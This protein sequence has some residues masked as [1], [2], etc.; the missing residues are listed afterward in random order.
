MT[1]MANYQDHDGVFAEM[2]WTLPRLSQKGPLHVGWALSQSPSIFHPASWQEPREVCGLWGC[3][4]RQ[5]ALGRHVTN[6]NFWFLQRCWWTT[7]RAPLGLNGQQQQLNKNGQW[8]EQWQL[9]ITND[10]DNKQLPKSGKYRGPRQN[11]VLTVFFL[12]PL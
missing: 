7:K 4:S 1:T 3:R 6:V 5:I 9:S 11:S 12:C 8:W 10:D 2:D